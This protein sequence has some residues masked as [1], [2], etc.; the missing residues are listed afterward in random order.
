MDAKLT[1]ILNWGSYVIYKVKLLQ[2]QG[3]LSRVHL[4]LRPQLGLFSQLVNL[5]KRAIRVFISPDQWLQNQFMQVKLLQNQGLLS[6]VH[7]SSRP[8]TMTL[9][10]I[11]ES[12]K[13]SYAD[14]IDSYLGNDPFLKQFLPID[15][16][17]KDLFNLV[18]RHLFSRRW[19]MHHVRDSD[20]ER[21]A[22]LPFTSRDDVDFFSHL[23]M[24][25]RQDHPPMCGRDHM[26]YRSTYFP[27][28]DV[29]D[30]DLCEQFP[31]L[32][33][34]TEKN[35]RSARQ[36]I[37]DLSVIYSP[38]ATC[39]GT[40]K[41]F[42]FNKEEIAGIL[43]ELY[44][45]LSNE[46]ESE[47]F[48]KEAA[49]SFYCME[50]GVIRDLQGTGLPNNKGLLRRPDARQLLDKMYNGR[51]LSGSKLVNIVVPGI[52]DERAVNIRTR[53]LVGGRDGKAYAY[54]LNIL[55]PD[56]CNPSMLDTK[57]PKDRARVILD[58]A[59]RASAILKRRYDNLFS[60]AAVDGRTRINSH[61]SVHMV[62]RYVGPKWATMAW[63]GKPKRYVGPKWATMS[64]C[65]KGTYM[66]L[67]VELCDFVL[68]HLTISR[69]RAV[70]IQEYKHRQ[71]ALI[72]CS[73]GI[74]KITNTG[75][76]GRDT[77]SILTA[78]MASID[79]AVRDIKTLRAMVRDP[80]PDAL[81]QLSGQLTT[82]MARKSSKQV[83][84]QKE[85][86]VGAHNPAANLTKGLNSLLVLILRLSCYLNKTLRARCKELRA[87]VN[88]P[89][90]DALHE[91]LNTFTIA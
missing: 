77:P 40:L 5:R 54:L 15:P 38:F 43:N 39:E 69:F 73:K 81:Q 59:E 78:E 16:A 84:N 3:L 64:C 56:H 66:F 34:C 41:A 52:I 27:V 45:D 2:N 26:A 48:L 90:P 25:L 67:C 22:L 55:A 44:G 14:Q 20:G 32:P 21:G 42:I 87:M 91:K 74:F 24:L 58:H 70:E 88:D 50:L 82:E 23:E 9:F 75:I 10:A 36:N 89:L 19:R 60:H 72:K 37:N 62:K 57:D 79:E 85:K 1:F 63:Y 51:I 33:L 65:E 7:L 68:D 29:I 35:C 71:V 31:T 61:P 12:E 30:G 6:R 28:K 8:Q 11:S 13:A 17:T 86:R 80:L 47:D 49:Y 76:A 46:I 53:D 4:S 18:K 83:R